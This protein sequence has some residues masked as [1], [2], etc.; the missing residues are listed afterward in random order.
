[1]KAKEPTTAQHLWVFK[2]FQVTTWWSSSRMNVKSVQGSYQRKGWLFRRI[3]NMFNELFHTI[4][5][6][7][8]SSFYH[9]DARKNWDSGLPCAVSDWL[10]YRIPNLHLYSN[11]KHNNWL[12]GY[13][14]VTDTECK[15]LRNT[16]WL[17][18]FLKFCLAVYCLER[19]AFIKS[20]FTV[21]SLFSRNVWYLTN[22]TATKKTCLTHLCQFKGSVLRQ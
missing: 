19:G 9:Q 1:M 11:I 10:I 14:K 8:Y 22:F 6:C 17:L 18:I 4:V 7:I 3:K 12:K 15:L 20:S 13:S 16:N 5:L 21:P 2:S